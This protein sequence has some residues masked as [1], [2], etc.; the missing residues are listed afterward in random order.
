MER[1]VKPLA[2]TTLNNSRIELK[3][4]FYQYCNKPSKNL[5]KC[6]L[7]KFCITLYFFKTNFRY[8]NEF[9]QHYYKGM[10]DKLGLKTDDADD[11]KLIQ[12]LLYTMHQ[13][14]S[15]FTNT[16][17]ILCGFSLLKENDR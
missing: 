9:S 4:N 15:D 16:F 17:Q 12:N 2:S 10:K 5:H 3:Q 6:L 13:S 7:M 1:V 11:E 14:A 8:D